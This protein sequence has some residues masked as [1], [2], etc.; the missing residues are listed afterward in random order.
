M[1]D[2]PQ[3]NQE[4]ELYRT[5]IFPS[6]DKTQSAFLRLSNRPLN[7]R[8]TKLN[9]HRLIHL[10]SS[11]AP[12]KHPFDYQTAL[13]RGALF[14]I[15][16]GRKRQM[17]SMPTGAGK[18]ATAV[19]LIHELILSL[20]LNRVLWLAPST[21]LVKQ[22]A[23][24]FTQTWSTKLPEASLEIHD[25]TSTA[26]NLDAV[27]IAVTTI[28]QL[29]HR[30]HAVQVF[31]PLVVVFDEAHQAAAPRF[32]QA[33]EEAVNVDSAVLIGLSAT[34]GRGN[35][36]ELFD[37]SSLFDEQLSVPAILGPKPI[38]YLRSIGVYASIDF[39]TIDLGSSAD[40]LS[41]RDKEQHLPTNELC[42]H[43]KRFWPTI[44]RIAAATQQAPII[45]F[46]SSV[47]HSYAIQVALANRRIRSRTLSYR[48]ASATREEIIRLFKA[49]E[50]PVLL[51]V[52]ILNTGF[53]YP[54]LS[55]V[56]VTAPVRSPVLWEQIV[57]RVAR[58]PAVGGT[59]HATVYQVDRH[60]L[61]H[62]QLQSY[63]RFWGGHWS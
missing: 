6:D 3:R 42:S 5:R 52:A 13:I 21:E 9:E 23:D 59:K 26:Q 40:Y 53:D 55:Q 25:V 43:P 51:N 41:V 8:G 35:S 20:G 27:H 58:G 33:I 60:D 16:A 38:D 36:S 39:D 18:T 28:Q 32:R 56:A 11:H 19:W 15:R 7:S 4:I 10:S 12:N 54:E 57:G 34:P 50:L 47:I 22:A 48:T 1:K 63:A 46:A 29:L 37:L 14:A 44:E 61:I 24:A 17:L 30:G 2:S 62:G 31:S 49:G 45:V